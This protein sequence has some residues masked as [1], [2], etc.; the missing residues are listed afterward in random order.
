VLQWQ[1]VQAM[2]SKGVRFLPCGDAALTVEFGYEIDR[3]ISEAVLAL[4]SA[5]ACQHVEG[6]VETVPTFR[7]LMI[8]F[9]P[10]T[11]TAETLTELIRDLIS[12]PSE[13]R[14][15]QLRWHIPACYDTELAP[16][17]DEVASLTGLSSGEVVDLHSGTEFHV[18]MIGFLPGYPYMG[19]LPQ[20]L[21][22]P[23][24]REPR[25]RL[26]AGSIAIATAMTAIYPVECP[27]GWHLI[28]KSPIKLFD[29]QWQRP[30]LLAPGDKVRFVPISFSQ[31]E[32]VRRDV[33]AGRY[34][35]RCETVAP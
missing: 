27:G 24:R 30:S 23:R 3:S 20:R 11:V 7:S 22:L 8:H 10:L 26:P 1:A 31:F 15:N 6:I 28:G 14:P 2:H 19:D 35:P 25:L 18:Y 32:A 34:A 4:D 9:E 5:L 17:L 13:A 33:A 21:R 29:A 16:D 12:S